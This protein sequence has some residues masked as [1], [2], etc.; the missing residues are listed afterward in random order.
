MYLL[1]ILQCNSGIDYQ[2]LP[3][4]QINLSGDYE[5]TVSK[6]CVIREYT[7]G[8]RIFDS[9]D[10]CVTERRICGRFHNVLE[11][12]TSQNIG[13]FPKENPDRFLVKASF[14]SLDGYA[15]NGVLHNKKNPGFDRDSIVKF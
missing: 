5:I 13:L 1:D 6:Q 8:Y 10:G 2:V 9:H 3:D 4:L 15:L 12:C 11:P 14:I 7:S